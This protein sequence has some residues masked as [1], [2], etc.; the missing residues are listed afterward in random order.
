MI[1]VVA[2]IRTPEPIS[3]MER[4]QPEAYADLCRNIAILEKHYGD[5]QVTR[6]LIRTVDIHYCVLTSNI[7]LLLLILI[8]D[9]IYIN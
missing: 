4:T 6:K 1:T 7:L 3:N 5:M 2:G 9:T 8:K